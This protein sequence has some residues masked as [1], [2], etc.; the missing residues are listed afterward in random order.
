MTALPSVLYTACAAML[1]AY[2]LTGAHML[3]GGRYGVSTGT[4]SG[5]VRSPDHSKGQE[6]T[7]SFQ[8]LTSPFATAQGAQGFSNRQGFQRVYGRSNQ[9]ASQAVTPARGLST[10]PRLSFARPQHPL[11]QQRQKATR[12][13]PSGLFNL[14]NTCYMNAALQVHFAGILYLGFKVGV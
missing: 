6:P 2:R 4:G 5:P 3:P 8:G 9:A 1:Q 12:E 13:L 11:L 10:A 14:G 7:D